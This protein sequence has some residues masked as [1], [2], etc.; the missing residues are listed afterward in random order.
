MKDKVDSIDEAQMAHDAMEDDLDDM[1]D[2]MHLD[3]LDD[4]PF[5]TGHPS[6]IVKPED[7]ADRYGI[8]PDCA[9][10]GVAGGIVE[11]VPSQNFCH[12]DEGGILEALA[13]G[14]PVEIK[15]M[16]Y[17]CPAC[18]SKRGRG[19]KYDGERS[20]IYCPDCKTET[21]RDDV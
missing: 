4:L 21:E 16:L 10:T 8:C 20:V 19:R 5:D 12:C 2:E 7:V 1:S 17:D 6:M 9:D 13:F 14:T 18:G 11:G 3:E 15:M